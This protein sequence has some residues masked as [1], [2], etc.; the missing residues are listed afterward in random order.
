VAGATVWGKGRKTSLVR[1]QLPEEEDK[2]IGR[3]QAKGAGKNCQKKGLTRPFNGREKPDPQTE[4][5]EMSLRAERG[6][7]S[8]GKEG[9][10]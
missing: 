4:K 2:Q 9:V 3:L 5:G 1:T 8:P 6:R 7:P 10:V